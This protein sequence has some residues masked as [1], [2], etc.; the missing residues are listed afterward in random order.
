MGWRESMVYSPGLR[1]MSGNEACAEAAIY[2]GCRF[3]GGY[4]IT[5]S[6]EI[7]E[8]LSFRLPQNGGHFIQ[9]EDEI[10]SIASV[11]G[12][13]LGGVKSLTAT[14]GPGFSLM[15][16][17]IGYG[18]IA[19]IPCVIIDVQRGGPSTGVPTGSSQGDIMQARWGTHGDH[20]SIALYPASVTECFELTVRA[21][22]LAEHYRTPVILLSDE[23]IGHM[24]EA[25]TMP[26]VGEL[27]V[28]DRRRPRRDPDNYQPYEGDIPTI[29]AFGEG[30]RFHVTGLYHDDSGFPTNDPT[31][32]GRQERRIVRKVIKN[33]H[34][35]IEYDGRFLDDAKVVVVA[36]GAVARSAIAAVKRARANGRKVGLFRLKTIWPFP[37]DEI[38]QLAANVDTFIV[39]EMNMGQLFEIVTMAAKGQAQIKRINRVD[40]EIITPSQIQRMIRESF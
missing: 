34:D 20:P 40:C 24:R 21:F 37:Q 28:Y 32:I 7:A 26:V 31:S 17:N 30:Y 39:P 18:C 15:Q 23:I 8:I 25:F 19:E 2:A 22:N 6:T 36:A 11:L 35:I 4:P 10:A 27:K 9:M 13:S 3:F 14:S 38:E 29:S 1:L 33:R 5:P 12:A 16:E